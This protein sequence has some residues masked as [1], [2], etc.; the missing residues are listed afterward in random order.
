MRSDQNRQDRVREA[1]MPGKTSKVFATY[2]ICNGSSS[3]PSGS[4]LETVTMP[5]NL[6]LRDQSRAG[7]C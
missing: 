1:V 7:A 4:S 6:S 2:D 3:F 5:K